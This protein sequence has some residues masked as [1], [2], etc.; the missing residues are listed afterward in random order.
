[1]PVACGAGD[2]LRLSKHRHK[3]LQRRRIKSAAHCS[4]TP[5]RHLHPKRNAT[6]AGV[7]IEIRR[8]DWAYNLPESMIPVRDGIRAAGGFA[9]GAVGDVSEESSARTVSVFNEFGGDD[10]RSTQFCV[11]LTKHS[12][13]GKEIPRLCR[14]HRVNKY[15]MEP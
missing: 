13:A 4:P 5:A 14:C 10:L 3:A 2:V 6:L 7:G 15:V 12:S 1:M 11:T 9:F 8:I